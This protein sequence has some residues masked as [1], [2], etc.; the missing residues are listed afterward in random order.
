MGKCNVD[1]EVLS[2][3]QIGFERKPFLSLFGGA[4]IFAVIK[5]H[6]QQIKSNSKEKRKT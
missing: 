4:I 2:L 1:V 3:L 5:L 6:L